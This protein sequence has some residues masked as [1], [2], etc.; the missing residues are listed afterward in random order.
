MNHRQKKKL[1][2]VSKEVDAAFGGCSYG[3][4]SAGALPSEAECLICGH[5]IRLHKEESSL[6]ALTVVHEVSIT[7][8]T[9]AQCGESRIYTIREVDQ[10]AS[11][12]PSDPVAPEGGVIVSL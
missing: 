5:V 6:C 12:R 3:F 2:Y 7:L 9:H 4:L 8:W 1:V 10:I 11:T